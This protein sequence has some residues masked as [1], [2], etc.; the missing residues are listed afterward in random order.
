MPERLDD[1][2]MCEYRACRKKATKQGLTLRYCPKHWAWYMRHNPPK[3]K[4]KTE[5]SGEKNG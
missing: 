3:P 1:K 5:P 2:R 4:P